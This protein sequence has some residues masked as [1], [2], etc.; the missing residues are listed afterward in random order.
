MK[1]WD[2]G[3]E[4]LTCHVVRHV[5][6]ARFVHGIERLFFMVPVFLSENNSPVR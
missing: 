6:R 1:G 2:G 3:G 5:Y 4:F